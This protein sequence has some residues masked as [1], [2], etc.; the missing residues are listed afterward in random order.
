M[1]A[2]QEI[3]IRAL[4][5]S[6]ERFAGAIESVAE[7]PTI[8]RLNGLVGR[9]EM[10]CYDSENMLAIIQQN[11]HELQ[12]REAAIAAR[13]HE[14]GEKEVHRGWM[15]E[16]PMSPPES[17]L[18]LGS[19]LEGVIF[20]EHVMIDVCSR[21]FWEELQPED[22]C[23]EA[24]AFHNNVWT[25]IS[26][27]DKQGSDFP[28]TKQLLHCHERGCTTSAEEWG[29]YVYSQRYSFQV[30]NEGA[31]LPGKPAS[32]LPAPRKSVPAQSSS[33]PA[34]HP[35]RPAPQTARQVPYPP[36]PAPKNFQGRPNATSANTMTSGPGLSTSQARAARYRELPSNNANMTRP[37]MLTTSTF[38][39][40]KDGR[41]DDGK[42]CAPRPVDS[43]SGVSSNGAESPLLGWQSRPQLECGAL[44]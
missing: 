40:A 6:I 20:M 35:P 27:K 15:P 19:Y 38:R 25:E 16:V 31:E 14:L 30:E 34:P 29:D 8:P 10:I 5:H 43:F 24:K 36:R 33:R 26:R 39:P 42:T 17:G 21:H 2:D 3:T 1:D 7:S 9:A 41:R 4:K 44:I 28:W 32:P 18:G 11:E 13:E 37:L 22:I 23:D 12:A